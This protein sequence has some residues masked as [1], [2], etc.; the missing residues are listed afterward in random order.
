MFKHDGPVENLEGSNGNAIIKAEYDY[1]VS[2]IR[3]KIILRRT[4]N[5]DTSVTPKVKSYSIKCKS[6]IS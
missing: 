5:I 3:V 6:L 4:S 2:G 1:I